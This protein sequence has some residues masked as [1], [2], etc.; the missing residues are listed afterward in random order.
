[1][2]RFEAERGQVLST[3]KPLG[4]ATI[5][6]DRFLSLSFVFRFAPVNDVC[7]PLVKRN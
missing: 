2:Y 1:M 7:V 6:D 4:H 5:D 3:R